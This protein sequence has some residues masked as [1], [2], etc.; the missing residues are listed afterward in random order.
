MDEIKQYVV[1]T[2]WGLKWLKFACDYA[3]NGGPASKFAADVLKTFDDVEEDP[4]A[5]VDTHI[6]TIEQRVVDSTN[7]TLKATEV[8]KV[9]KVLKKGLRSAFAASIAKVAYN[10]FGERKMS[11]ANVLVTRKWLAKYLAEDEFKD[12]RIC[13]KNLAID[14]ALFLSFIPTKDF[15]AMRLA[16]ATTCWKDRADGDS[17]FGKIFR[18]VSKPDGLA[19]P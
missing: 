19:L 9:R 11:E 15:Q 2:K 17:V 3:I 8:K 7:M 16:T 10:K 13:D 5:Y 14:R 12:L 1:I 4:H 18:L 6:T